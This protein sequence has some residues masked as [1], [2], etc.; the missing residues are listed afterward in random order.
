MSFNLPT[1]AIFAHR[2][3]SQDLPE[4]TLAAFELALEQNAD[5]IELDVHLSADREV[6]VIHDRDLSRTTN[7]SGYVDQT[8]LS[9]LRLLDAGGGQ[10]IPTLAEVIDLAADR[11]TLNIE[12][13]GF[14]TS[15][16]DLP[17]AVTD[18][19]NAR[20]VMQKVIF[21]SFHPRLLATIRRLLPEARI[22]LLTTAGMTG[23]LVK[24]IYEPRL[25]PSSLHPHFSSVTTGY[26]K[27]AQAK[28]RLVLAY[29]VNQ[30][31][32]MRHL[33]AMGI[34]GIITDDPLTAR[35]IRE[36]LA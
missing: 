36:E 25:Q 13:K 19:I 9:D 16:A 2:G 27:K 24:M 22:G 1:T 29:T 28:G 10:R 15:A 35:R 34:D 33:F 32:D 8:A 14:S 17:M 20:G 23:R 18:L 12:L 21:S 4:N 31:E 3:A 26:L 7:G 11:V 30:P 5:G 6:V